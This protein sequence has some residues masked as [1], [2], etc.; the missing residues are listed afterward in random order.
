[1]TER[2]LTL[3]LLLVSLGSLIMARPNTDDRSTPAPPVVEPTL[4][5]FSA[6]DRADVATMCQ[7]QITTVEELLPVF[8]R[9][10]EKYEKNWRPPRGLAFHEWRD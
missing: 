5:I 2:F 9:L 1:M 4:F 10:A 3:V 6:T 7:V 8:C